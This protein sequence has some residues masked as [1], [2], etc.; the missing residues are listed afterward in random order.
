MTTQTSPI[1]HLTNRLQDYFD[2]HS[3]IPVTD[4]WTRLLDGFLVRVS[5]HKPGGAV[6]LRPEHFGL[7]DDDYGTLQKSLRW[8]TL[9][10]LNEDL[11][12]RLDSLTTQVRKLPDKWGVTVHW[13][14]YVPLTAI[15][16]FKSDFARLEV[17][18]NAE[19][20]GWVTNYDQHRQEAERKAT[21][22]AKRAAENAALL[23]HGRA[24]IDIDVM[25]AAIM[26]EYPTIE[27]VQERFRMAYEVSFIP[28]PTLEAEQAAW[29]AEVEAQKR[30]RLEEMEAEARMNR[31]YDELE[32]QRT[33]TAI[34][35]EQAK[36]EQKRRALEEHRQQLQRDLEKKR[37]E[38][39]NMF[40]Q[41]YAVEIRQRLHE[42][43]CYLMELAQEGK[44]PPQ[45]VRMAQKSLTRVLDELKHMA[46][47]DDDEI[48]AMRERLQSMA[49]DSKLQPAMVA[50]QIEDLGTLLQT[51]IYLLGEAPRVP[52]RMQGEP[53]MD[54]T[55]T[56][57]LDASLLHQ[58]VR[59]RRE[60]CGLDSSLA[61][62]LTAGG[63]VDLE[64]ARRRV[65]AEAL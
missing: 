20:A 9:N 33:I 26:S 37:D 49:T 40:Y 50:Q 15:E 21:V 25:V 39:V 18:W 38:L 61:E 14:Q 31:A 32:Y 44:V 36:N 23:N 41:R 1:D 28:T 62:T 45:K 11:Q 3:V 56:L 54:V 48:N 42:S 60:R 64:G 55:A 19:L 7:T 52:K 53:P 47:D 24:K 58:E 27:E 16:Q 30:L 63:E 51:S 10:L 43:L 57:P 46:M 12:G 2:S 22:L 35:L 5:V 59:T 8:S 29:A 6:R 65:R 13:G 4:P 34:Q 17:E